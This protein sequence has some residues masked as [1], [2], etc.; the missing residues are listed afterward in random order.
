[1]TPAKVLLEELEH[2]YLGSYFE[3]I[4]KLAFVSVFSMT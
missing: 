3:A 2:T 1:M 4:A